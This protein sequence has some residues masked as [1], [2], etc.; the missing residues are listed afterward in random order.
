[1]A[2]IEERGNTQARGSVSVEERRKDRWRWATHGASAKESRGGD[3]ARRCSQMRISPALV[4]GEGASDIPV[5]KDTNGD[6]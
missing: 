3:T 4:A 2:L 5:T 1:M 6:T